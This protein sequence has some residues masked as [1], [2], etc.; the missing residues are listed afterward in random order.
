MNYAV[1]II[2]MSS[3]RA[4]ADITQLLNPDS[5]EI[6]RGCKAEKTLE[7]AKPPDSFQFL[8]L[9]YFTVDSKHSK[10][11]A[12]VFNRAVALKDGFKKT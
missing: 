3:N 11:G 12:P 1:S 9:G 6:L 10:P 8:R 2:F 7:T 5:L 4:D